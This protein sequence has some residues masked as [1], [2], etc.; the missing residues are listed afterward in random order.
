MQPVLVEMK[1][2]SKEF[3]GVRALKDV[4]FTVAKGEILG[5]I[6]ENGAGKSTL[7]KVL[8][9]VYPAESGEIFYQGQRLHLTNPGEAYRQG[10]SIIFQEFNLCPNLSAMENIFLGKEVKSAAGLISYTK[11]RAAATALFQRLKIDIDP[12]I[13]VR[14]LGVAQ[15]QMVEIAK[16]LSYDT[17]LLIMDEPTSSLAATEIDNL[18]SI[19]RD[20]KSN[21]IAVV[22]I[23]HKLDE[24]LE[25]S[26]RIS[27]LRDGEHVG[28]LVTADTHKNEIIGLMVGR[29][30]GHLF[31]KR[32]GKPAQEIALEVQGLSGPPN[33]KD[34][35]FKLYKGEILGLAG[36]VGAGRTELANLLM[37]STKKIAGKTLLH[38]QEV[39]IKHPSD[40][41]KSGIGYVPEDRKNLGLVLPMAARENLSMAIHP[42]LI[43]V[44]NIINRKRE[45]ETCNKYVDQLRIKISSLKQ[46]TKNLSGGNQQ[47]V[48]IGKWLATTPSVLILDEPTRGIDVGAKAE[49]HRIIV[50]LADEGVSILVISSELPEILGLA[51][52]VLVMHEGR[53]TADLSKEQADQESI[54]RAAVN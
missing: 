50:E 22:F 25:I 8:T 19:V 31:T 43:N 52:R 28:D 47:K 29:E 38:G 3:P 4:D 44:F 36:L 13:E 34:V 15:Q 20:L 23:S 32:K 26:E 33:T 7:M 40:A 41:V 42:K 30:L 35:S 48:V 11:T 21:G 45:A 1:G 24:M 53:I 49:V 17:K 16:A 12:D 39:T 10:I 51:D 37:G 27:V 54:M 46:V 6:G 2:I 14:R 9:G 18:F 5:L